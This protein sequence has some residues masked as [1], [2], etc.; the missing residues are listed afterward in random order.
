MKK[1]QENMYVAIYHNLLNV[2][3]SL[4][5]KHNKSNTFLE[6]KMFLYVNIEVMRYIVKKSQS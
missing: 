5:Y 1:N 6:Q 4:L 2:I 3:I